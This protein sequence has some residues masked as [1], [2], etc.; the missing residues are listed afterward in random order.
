MTTSKF[1]LATALKEH[2]FEST[3]HD[4]GY[5]TTERFT[6]Q[7]GER[8]YNT[9]ARTLM[10]R[11]EIVVTVEI[12]TYEDGSEYISDCTQGILVDHSRTG[13]NAKRIYNALKRAVEAEGFEF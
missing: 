3:T 10:D 9:F 5:F 11:L 4:G 2:G 7:Y 6:K 12:S 1:D 13:Q 8:Y